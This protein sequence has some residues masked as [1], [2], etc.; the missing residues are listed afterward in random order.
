MHTNVHLEGRDRGGLVWLK[1]PT[2]PSSSCLTNHVS[3]LFTHH[4]LGGFCFLMLLFSLNTSPSFWFT[5]NFL[6]PWLLPFSLNLLPL[7]KLFFLFALLHHFPFESFEFFLFILFFSSVRG[8]E[9]K[10]FSAV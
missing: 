1:H 7:Y 9:N 4:Y 6:L 2:I 8:V 10:S 5:Q 3:F